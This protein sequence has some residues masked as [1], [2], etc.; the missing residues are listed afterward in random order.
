MRK[1]VIGILVLAASQTPAFGW[2]A[3]GH[4]IIGELAA[5]NFP[6]TL[7]AFL[8]T[9]EA[10]FQIG[11]LSREPDISKG[12]GQPHD[13]DL[14]PGHYVNVSDDGTIRGGPKLSDLPPNRRDFDTALR[15]VNSNQYATGYLPYSLMGSYQ[16]LVKDFAIL[17]MTMAAQKHAKKFA[18]TGAE[19][20]RFARERALREMLTLRDLGWL[21]HFVGDTANPMHA[22]IHLNGWRG[23]TNPQGFTTARNT[24]ARFEDAFVEANIDD[25]DV[26]E[27][28]KPYRGCAC[29]IQ[30]RTQD[31]LAASQALVVQT[32][33]LEKSGAIDTATPASKSFVAERLAEGAGQLRDWVTDAWE[34]SARSTLGYRNPMSVADLESGKADPRLLN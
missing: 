17:R 18:M 13:A 30:Q 11:Q 2:G 14:D 23:E 6:T 3:K 20:Q 27:K 7:P 29:T 34:E 8:K 12:A 9:P 32:Y 10:Q 21:G 24:Q 22:T 16:Q 26:A 4:R 31:Y 19:R 15:A 1:L 25:S 28:L 5:K 33:E